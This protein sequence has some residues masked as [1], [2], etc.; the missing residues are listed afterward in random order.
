MHSSTDKCIC[1]LYWAGKVLS[2]RVSSPQH[3]GRNNHFELVF[4]QRNDLQAAYFL[5]APCL[6]ETFSHFIFLVIRG[7]S[8][9]TLLPLPFHS[10]PILRFL[11]IHHLFHGP[12]QTFFPHPPSFFVSAQ[13]FF[14]IFFHFF[15]SPSLFFFFILT[16]FSSTYLLLCPSTFIFYLLLLSSSLSSHSV[17]ARPFHL[18]MREQV[19]G[20]LWLREE[21]FWRAG[22]GVPLLETFKEFQHALSRPDGLFPCHIQHSA[23]LLYLNSGFCTSQKLFFLH[24]D[25]EL[26]GACNGVWIYFLLSAVST[27]LVPH[28]PSSF[29]HPHT[30]PLN[31]PLS[32]SAGP[33]YFCLI[34]IKISTQGCLSIPPP[35]LLYK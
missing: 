26:F 35:V 19:L 5:P 2:S 12:T 4:V 30:Q 25:L 18:S 15:H 16:F 17:S 1:S 10:S 22:R 11:F 14:L 33:L 27:H 3:I 7:L 29:P 8:F 6:R 31:L 28:T 32:P 9:P 21:T 24:W 13:L 34:S 23:V 20:R